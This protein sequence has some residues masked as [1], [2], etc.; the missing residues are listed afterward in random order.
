MQRRNSGTAALRG[1]KPFANAQL[2]K[3]KGAEKKDAD[4]RERKRLCKGKVRK[5]PSN[6]G[7]HKRLSVSQ[8]TA[9]TNVGPLTIAK[10][11][12]FVWQTH[13]MLPCKT[14]SFGECFDSI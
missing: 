8:M 3:R 9:V 11:C 12:C 5:Q 7:G 13:Q 10:Y 1:C 2:K 14:S 6:P 4:R